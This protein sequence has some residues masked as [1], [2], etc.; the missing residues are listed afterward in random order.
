MGENETEGRMDEIENKE[1]MMF[2][3]LLGKW[4]RRWLGIWEGDEGKLLRVFFGSLT[5]SLPFVLRGYS[6][7][8]EMTGYVFF[9]IKFP[10]AV[11]ATAKK[12][13]RIFY[14]GRKRGKQQKMRRCNKL[15][16]YRRRHLIFTSS[17]A[18]TCGLLF[19]ILALAAA[20]WIPIVILEHCI[21]RSQT[22]VSHR[23]SS[24]C[25]RHCHD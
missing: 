11:A 1:G 23:G 18:K 10:F 22:L 12:R 2:L 3:L 21:G 25:Q 17:Y 13:N 16:S 14:V 9:S 20:A 15:L 7:F 8:F 5:F 6:I 4:R 19:S 24:F